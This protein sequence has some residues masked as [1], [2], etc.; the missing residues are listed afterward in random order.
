MS[1]PTQPST[2]NGPSSTV[3]LAARRLLILLIV[4]EH[5]TWNQARALSY[6][7]SFGLEEGLQANGC[8]VVTIPAFSGIG[9]SDRRGWLGRVQDLFRVHSFDQ[10]WVNASQVVMD[11]AMLSQL[12]VR[13]PVR[14]AFFDSS[15]DYSTEELTRDR[16]LAERRSRALGQLRAFTHIVCAEEKDRALFAQVGFDRS[17]WMPGFMPLRLIRDE[18][19]KPVRNT[20]CFTVMPG[21]P[22]MAWAAKPEHR[23]LLDPLKVTDDAVKIASRFDSLNHEVL[24]RLPAFPGGG[25]FPQAVHG[26]HIKLLRALRNESVE[27]QLN[28]LRQHLAYVVDPT[29]QARLVEKILLSLAGGVPVVLPKSLAAQIASVVG[30][31]GLLVYDEKDPDSL[32]ALLSALA[33]NPEQRRERAATGLAAMRRDFSDIHRLAGCLEWIRSAPMAAPKDLPQKAGTSLGPSNAADR[34]GSSASAGA[35]PVRTTAYILTI[36][37]PVFVRCR[38]ALDKQTISNFDIDII[39]HISPISAAGTEMLRRCKTE[40]LIQIDEDMILFPDAVEKME[41]YIAAAPDNVGM[42]CFYLYDEDRE[43]NIQGIKIFRTSQIHKV[44]FRDTKASDMDLIDQM[45]SLGIKW[46]AHPDVMGLHGTSYSLESIYLR[47]KTMY[48][49]DIRLWNIVTADIWRKA[50]KYRQTGDPLQLFALLG[51]AHGVINAPFAADAEKNFNEYR[52]KSIEIFKRL[53]ASRPPHASIYD[54]AVQVPP[55]KSP[56][57]P[58]EQVVWKS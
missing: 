32:K 53:L 37:D 35:Q 46:V 51:A 52:L 30:E 48:E 5:Q 58:F 19:Q 10:V 1:S 3:D 45:D 50:E 33:A 15:L 41:R 44:Y 38:E 8:D 26:P 39:D 16:S 28:Q 54:P 57:I 25:E 13:V 2:A 11:S 40:F 55:S 14:V 56:P 31:E 24:T 6:F 36:G 18:P 34:Q 21:S 23:V 29:V 22:L 27:A 43:E 4:P 20:A 42:I 47:Y 17:Y 7:W 49:K 9:A 12:E